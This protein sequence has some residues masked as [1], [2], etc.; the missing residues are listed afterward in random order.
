MFRPG[1]LNTSATGSDCAF[2][3]TVNGT[4][5]PFTRNTDPPA[6]TPPAGRFGFCDV[7]I[8]SS[9][10]GD[11]GATDDVAEGVGVGVA[12]AVGSG[13]PPPP[14]GGAGT[15]AGVGVGVGVLPPHCAGTPA[16]A[17]QAKVGYEPSVI[18][19]LA[20]SHA[21]YVA[22]VF[23][24]GVVFAPAVLVAASVAAVVDW[25]DVWESQNAEL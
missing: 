18:V 21:P 23:I 16:P 8:G 20:G 6:G 2:G 1:A 5:C 19:H 24:S 17:V 10:A 4:G 22:A 13:T 15:G 11:A 25:P 12:L 14:D 7:A 9:R 3:D